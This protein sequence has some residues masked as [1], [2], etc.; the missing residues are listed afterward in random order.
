MNFQNQSLSSKRTLT[1]TKQ[2]AKSMITYLSK[3]IQGAEL[4]D[5]SYFVKL[6]IS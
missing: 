3:K 4:F 5:H 2:S 1:S 6:N